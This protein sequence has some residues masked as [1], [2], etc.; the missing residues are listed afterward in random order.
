[1]KFVVV[2][3]KTTIRPID[4]A[5]LIPLEIARRRSKFLCYGM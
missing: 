2:Q 1:M 3:Y 5:G 4:D